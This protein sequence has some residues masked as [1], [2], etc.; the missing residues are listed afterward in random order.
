MEGGCGMLCQA[1]I[2]Y[3]PK[4]KKKKHRLVVGD[5]GFKYRGEIYWV[6]WDGGPE[7][8]WRERRYEGYNRAYPTSS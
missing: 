7:D 2:K 8:D 3:S 4:Y 5:V 6:E 1:W